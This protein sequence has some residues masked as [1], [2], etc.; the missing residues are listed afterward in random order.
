M[1]FERI[2]EMPKL[3]GEQQLVGKAG[4]MKD[5]EYWF[6]GHRTKD[7]T[8]EYFTIKKVRVTG[9]SRKVEKAYNAHFLPCPACEV[10]HY[11][12]NCHSF[13]WQGEC[14]HVRLL[15]GLLDLPLKPVEG[16]GDD[17]QARSGR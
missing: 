6:F 13:F 3:P 4:Y 10:G 1:W 12:C 11:V 5:I 8:G 2:A 15:V 9:V 17:E 16:E 7:D 14:K